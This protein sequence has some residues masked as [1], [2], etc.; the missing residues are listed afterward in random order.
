M[1][2]PAS[3]AQQGAS[4]LRPEPQA[5]VEDARIG[6]LREKKARQR[7]RGT[8]ADGRPPMDDT[9]AAGVQ[10]NEGRAAL[11]RRAQVPLRSDVGGAPDKSSESH[12]RHRVSLALPDTDGVGC[13]GQ[14]TTWRP[15]VCPEGNHAARS[16][17]TRAIE[18]NKRARGGET[19]VASFGAS[20]RRC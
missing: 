7:N 9:H 14:E 10:Q 6:R 5:A 19:A 15:G 13:P 3:C 11:R 20:S 2:E 18:T 17:E 4:C 1:V 8:T 16:A 12:I